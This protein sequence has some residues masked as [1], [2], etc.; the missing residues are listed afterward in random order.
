MEY[1]MELRNLRK[2]YKHFTLDNVSLSL[3]MGCIMG[4][5][6]ENGAGKSTTIKAVMGLIAKDGGRKSA[7]WGKIPSPTGL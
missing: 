4:F 7:C 6:G 3:P 2:E 5:I 1:A